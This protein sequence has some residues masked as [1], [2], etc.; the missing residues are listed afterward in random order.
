MQRRQ[1]MHFMFL[2]K[3]MHSCK[4]DELVRKAI[5]GIFS[6]FSDEEHFL[7]YFDTT[8]ISNDKI[9]NCYATTYHDY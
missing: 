6:K 1:S 5:A 3:I 7:K 9:C 2:G 8:W 4:D